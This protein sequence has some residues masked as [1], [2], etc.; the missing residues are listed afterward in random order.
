MRDVRGKKCLFSEIQ[1]S[2]NTNGGLQNF[3]KLY[4]R[5]YFRHA[6]VVLVDY[7]TS[8]GRVP[9]ELGISKKTCGYC[10]EYLRAVNEH[11]SENSPRWLTLG[12]HGA[13]VFSIRLAVD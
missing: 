9:T 11:L 3:D 7:L 2:Q 13:T 8:V 1:S 4:D 10:G 6:E 12:S 5:E